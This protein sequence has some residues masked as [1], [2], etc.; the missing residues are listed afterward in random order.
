MQKHFVIFFSPG[1]FIAEQSEYPIESWDV[2][3]A[4]EMAQSVKERYNTT[5]YGFQF[6]TRERKDNELDSR[7]VERSGMYFLGGEVLTVEQIRERN[8]PK[9]R[10]LLLNMEGNGWDKIVVNTNSWRW[11][12]PLRKGDVVL[13][14]TPPARATTNQP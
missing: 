6:T 14:F 8:D 3:K 5:P 13:D 2:Q 12:E 10:T 9:E 11:T 1:T 4:I 7:E